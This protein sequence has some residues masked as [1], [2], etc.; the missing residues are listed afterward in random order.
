[1]VEISKELLSEL[2]TK[3]NLTTFQIADKIGC[4]QATVWKKLKQYGIH[5][6][7]PGSPRVQ[8]TKN[9]LEELYLQKKLST[10]QMEKKLN[11]SRGTIHR[12]LI[13]FSIPIRDRSDSHVIHQKRDF[14]GN[15]IEKAYLIGFRI[16][17]L[18][19]RKQYPNSKTICI[20]TGSTVKE[21]IELVKS[22]FEDYGKVWIKEARDNKI[23]VQVILN[24]S[25]IF[26]LPKE[27]P[28]WVEQDKSTFFSFLAGF[29]DAEGIISE[30][31]GMA[32]YSL[33]NYDC[34]F[35]QRIHGNLQKFGIRCKE[36]KADNRK[37]KLNN[38]GYPYRSNYWT[39]RVHTKKDLLTLLNELRPYLKHKN[40]VQALSRA[41]V[42]IL[43]RNKRF[44]KK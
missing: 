14:S 37:G 44:N 32:Y 30:S 29:S 23:N 9:Q 2:Y 18:G 26:L 7:L 42:N 11:V 19:V 22:L 3:K 12:K 40:K 17:D 41:I 21:Q 33:G 39:L 27:F 24:Q 10:W 6:R 38:Q 35:L 4:C 8:T 31:Q 5:L 15:L 36:P 20:A 34:T 43:Q 13:E 25:F 16:G 1:M 28:A